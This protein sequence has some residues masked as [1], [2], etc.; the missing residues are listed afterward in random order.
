M[1]TAAATYLV[2]TL[3]T[4]T[5]CVF[6]LTKLI[7]A[8]LENLELTGQQGRMDWVTIMY[9]DKYSCH[10][11]AHKPPLPGGIYCLLDGFLYLLF[12]H[13]GALEHLQYLANMFRLPVLAAQY[14]GDSFVPAAVQKIRSHSPRDGA[15]V[16]FKDIVCMAGRVAPFHTP[17][18]LLQPRNA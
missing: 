11:A 1:Q 7:S 15:S 5:C 18:C 16:K 17:Y 13:G 10:K 14:A 4:S 3:L 9:S 6:Q 8:A 2:G 12:C